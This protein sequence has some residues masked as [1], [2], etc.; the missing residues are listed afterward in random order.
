MAAGFR[1]ASTLA[2][3]GACT[4]TVVVEEAVSG[5]LRSSLTLQVTV[6]VPGSAPLAVQGSGG[7]VAGNASS[8]GG[9][10]VSQAAAI[11]AAGNR[12]DG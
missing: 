4:F 2:G 11:G 7:G 9:V 8:A 6:I 10:A 12:T 1:A 5:G 3:G